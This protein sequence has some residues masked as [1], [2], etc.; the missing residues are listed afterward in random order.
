MW[1][2][3]RANLWLLLLTVVIC[4][5]IYP[6]AVWV[7]AQTVFHNQAQGSLINAKGEPVSDPKEAV[8]SRLIA[9]Q[10]NSAWF[11]LPRPSAASYNAAASGGSNYGAS[12][13]KL[14][15]RVAQ[16]LGPIVRY[17]EAYQKAHPKADG[18]AP[19]P[20]GDIKDWYKVQTAPTEAG[21]EKRDLFSEWA[22]N[23]STLAQA[24]ATGTPSIKDYIL[25]WAK[26]HP[27]VIADWKKDN[28]DVKTDPGAD[29]LVA[30]F[31]KSYSKEHFGQWPTVEGLS[32]VTTKITAWAKTHPEVATKWKAANPDAKDEP[33]DADLV[34][35]FYQ[36]YPQNSKDWPAP[37]SGE[38][39]DADQKAVVKPD[40]ADSDI[41]S[42]F[43]DTWM[44]E[45]VAAKKLDPLK[46]FEQ[47]PADMV[48]ASGSGLDPD[49]SLA[50]AQYQKDTVASA[51]AGK[52]A[53]D[54]VGQD[55]N[56][57]L[58]DDAKKKLQ[59]ELTTKLT[60]QI[61]GIVD[62]LLGDLAYRPMFGLTGDKP[63]VNVLE[64]NVR[65]QSEA[66]K[67]KVP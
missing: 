15:G 54:Y 41:Q 6:A 19:D 37:E 40:A 5:V 3:I 67:I 22:T 66:A 48:T 28:P 36:D 59:D 53:S 57:A 31:F 64:L 42:T 49:I 34:A 11:F 32:D 61:G 24:W 13:P 45:Q 52:L 50:N 63:L 65:L 51:Y 47:V 30:Y 4:C 12:N 35:F 56:K 10:F 44:T 20:Q 58:T 60:P 26:D 18:S 29:A 23:N 38:W 14:R 55:A 43:F 7:V 8:G 1:A 39:V 9:Q 17:T 25:Q 46:D 62:K 21:K 16:Q 27:D 2:H 33:K